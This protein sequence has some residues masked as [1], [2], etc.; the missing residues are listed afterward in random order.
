MNKERVALLFKLYTSMLRIR[1]IEKKI[2]KLWYQKRINSLMHLSIG[3][4]AVA[5][6]V[7]ANL[8]PRDS[9]MSTHRCHAHYLA[10][11][12]D[13]RAM[14]AE[15]AGKETGCCRG[16]GG[17]M[18]LFDSSVGMNLSV[19]I[20]GAS[21]SLAVGVALA[22]K[23]RRENRV[24]VV[25]FGD[26]AVDGG[27][28]WESVNFAAVYKLPMLFVCENNL[29][30]TH[31]PIQARQPSVDIAPRIKVHKVNVKIVDGNDVEAVY[32]TAKTMIAA[33]LTGQGPCFLEAKTYRMKEHWG[34][35]EDWH[36][37]YRSIKEGRYWKKRCPIR[38]AEKLLESN[39]NLALIKKEIN[40]EVDLAT[41][42]ALEENVTRSAQ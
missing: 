37:G 9:V 34:P 16:R 41:E 21:I 5:V 42:A 38:H 36:L 40:K 32:D 26:G 33:T 35:G 24:S 8:Q 2:I 39:L 17:S 11:G 14:L 27:N 12:G 29:Y 18:H 20:V 28:F 25:F 1:T 15:L 22:I 30:A 23:M 19:P 3:Q 4:E 31:S 10:K 7:C 13:L 6:G